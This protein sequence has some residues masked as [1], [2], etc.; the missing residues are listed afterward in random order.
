MIELGVT[1]GAPPWI[2]LVL[3]LGA[4]LF[5]GLERATGG[6]FSANIV[7]ANLNEYQVGSLVAYLANVWTMMPFAVIAASQLLPSCNSPSPTSTKVRQAEP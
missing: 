3:A 2:G 5:G 7:T 4:A 1:A 6:A